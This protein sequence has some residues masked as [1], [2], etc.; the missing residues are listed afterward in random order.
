MRIIQTRDW[1]I[2]PYI[3]LFVNIRA[4]WKLEKAPTYMQLSQFK[5]SV[6]L[7]KGNKPIVRLAREKEKNG[8]SEIPQAD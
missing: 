5:Y 4:E 8:A 7:C 1:P 3:L 6:E 2:I